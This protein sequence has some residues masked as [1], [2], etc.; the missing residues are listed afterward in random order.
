MASSGMLSHM[1]LVRTDVPEELSGSIIRVT[2]IGE[3]GQLAVTISVH[4]LTHGETSQT[5]PFWI[6][7]CYKTLQVNPTGLCDVDCLYN[8]LTDGGQVVSL[9]ARPR[10]NLHRYFLTL[11]SVS[12]FVKSRD[13]VRPEG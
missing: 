5:T 9:T 3:L 2:R 6:L 10:C 11:I 1:A 13:K 12:D 8:R 7:I 4:R